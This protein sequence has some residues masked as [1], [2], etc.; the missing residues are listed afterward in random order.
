[1]QLKDINVTNKQ[2]SLCQNSKHTDALNNALIIKHNSLHLIYT[3]RYNTR[4][5]EAGFRYALHLYEQI[6]TR[7]RHRVGIRRFTQIESEMV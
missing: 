7:S 4:W 5:G 6:Q 2:V 1:M 3:F